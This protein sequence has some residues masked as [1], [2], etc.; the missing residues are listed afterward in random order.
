MYPNN[1]IKKGGKNDNPRPLQA[2]HGGIR[3]YGGVQIKQNLMQGIQLIR[4]YTDRQ[5]R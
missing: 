5:L 3:P 4:M 2:P 1:H